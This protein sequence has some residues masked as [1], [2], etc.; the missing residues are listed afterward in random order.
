MNAI[1]A[2]LHCSAPS[3]PANFYAIQLN[4]HRIHHIVGGGW[5]AWRG[6]GTCCILMHRPSY[7]ARMGL[8][9]TSYIIPTTTIAAGLRDARKVSER[10]TDQIR[11]SFAASKTQ[12]REHCCNTAVALLL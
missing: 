8:V 7:Y 10:E 3:V 12:R 4:L 6:A 9:S 5:G 2:V 1:A 11:G